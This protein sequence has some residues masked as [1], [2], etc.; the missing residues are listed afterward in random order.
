MYCLLSMSSSKN[1]LDLS[2]KEVTVLVDGVWDED[3]DNF[4]LFDES[5]ITKMD[6]MVEKSNT[7]SKLSLNYSDYINVIEKLLVTKKYPAG[8]A[9]MCFNILRDDFKK[10]EEC[11]SKKQILQLCG[12]LLRKKFVINLSYYGSKVCQ[13]LMIQ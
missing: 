10:L 6:K 12:Q 4:E 7:N 11:E 3:S 2:F 9:T 8:L 5:I 1:G 13:S